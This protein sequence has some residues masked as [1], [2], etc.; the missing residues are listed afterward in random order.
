MKFNKL[1]PELS[2]SN[3]SRSRDFYL[4]LGFSVVYERMED[5]FIFLERDGNQ[6]MI[7]ENNTNWNTGELEFPYGRGVNFSM[8][9]IGCLELYNY[10]MKRKYPVYSEIMHN[11]YKVLDIDYTDTEFLIQDPDGYLLRFVETSLQ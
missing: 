10:L 4:D 6:I 5:K 9:I 1:I 11:T 8:E 7:Q 3:L 2:V